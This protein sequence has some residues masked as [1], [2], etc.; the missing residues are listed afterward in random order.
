MVLQ[1]S[2]SDHNVDEYCWCCQTCDAASAF[3]DP[4]P[5]SGACH[6]PMKLRRRWFPRF[7]EPRRISSLD[8]SSVCRYVSKPVVKV[9]TECV[10][11]ALKIHSHAWTSGRAGGGSSS[12]DVCDLDSAAWGRWNG[13]FV[14]GSRMARFGTAGPPDLE[15]G[16]WQ[17]SRHDSLLDMVRVDWCTGCSFLLPGIGVPCTR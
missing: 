6:Q 10:A 4:S 5:L 15:E 3:A 16:S 8:G 7:P 12:G 14:A 17:F 1:F 13:G 9:A 2:A 11:S